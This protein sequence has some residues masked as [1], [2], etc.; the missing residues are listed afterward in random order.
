MV[1]WEAVERLRSKGWDW[2][3]IAADPRAEFHA[4]EGM[5]EAG[6]ALRA[7]YYQR[8]S[9]QQRRPGPGGGSRK[10]GDLSD[11]P[12]WTLARVGMII[13]PAFGIWLG[14]ALLLPSPVGTYLPA[15]PVLVVLFL[16]AVFVLAFGLLRASE[17]WNTT[18]RNGVVVG[19]VLGFVLAGSLGLSAVLGGCPTLS[20]N[21]GPEPAQWE[22]AANPSWQSNGAPVFFFYGSIACPFCSASSWAVEFAL[23]KLG[24][25]TGTYYDHSSLTDTYPG[26]PEVVLASATLQSQWVSLNILETTDNTHITYPAFPSCTEQ[27]YVSAYDSTGIPFVV[28]NGQ[29]IHAG[30]LVDPSQLAGLNATTIQGQIAQH[31]GVAW[32]AVQSQGYFLLAY[33]VKANGGQPTSIATDPTVAA[34]LAQIT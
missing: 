24:T 33:L 17:R 9:R 6:R 27:A 29:Y 20:S 22:K 23:S 25:L 21:L 15:F 19:V 14:L 16:A 8:R 34:D 3:R 18:L 31:Q 28:V 2:D 7:L 12:K 13:A 5:G 30:T 26:T 32:N 10:S 1:D 4:E 11:R